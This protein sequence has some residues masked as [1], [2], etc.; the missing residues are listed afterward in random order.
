MA[1]TF[2]TCHYITWQETNKKWMIPSELIKTE[3]CDGAEKT[4]LQLSATNYGLCNMLTAEKLKDS[5]PSLKQSEGYQSLMEK[6]SKA[7]EEVQKV[8]SAAFWG[9]EENDD[10]EPKQKKQKKMK[11]MGTRPKAVE[12]GCDEFGTLTLKV[13]LKST[14]DLTILFTEDQVLTFFQFMMAHGA[15]SS[16]SGSKR[17][18]SKSGKYAKKDDTG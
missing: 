12:V 2:G 5:K 13:P 11:T 17:Q 15:E 1:L 18:Y 6:R 16:F 14:D 3:E 4:W 10:L 8:G 7:I 9:K